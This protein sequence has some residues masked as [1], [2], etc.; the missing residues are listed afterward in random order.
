[1]V[2]SRWPHLDNIMPVPKT[3]FWDHGSLMNGE[4]AQPDQGQMSPVHTVAH[5]GIC[6]ICRRHASVDELAP[7]F[8]SRGIPFTVM[9]DDRWQ[10]IGAV[11]SGVSLETIYASQG[12]QWQDVWVLDVGDHLMPGCL[13]AGEN[14]VL[15]TNE[16][17]R[18]FFVAA[19]RAAERLRFLYC[20]ESG[21]ASATR[22]LEPVM[23]Q[24]EHRR[25]PTH[26]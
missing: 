10:G 14:G 18:L 19:T 16:E 25:V 5:H 11:Q 24:L 20:R 26:T 22:F 12:M 2:A 4:T 23:G 8:R 13:G 7:V 1:M 21:L 9:G 3:F 17:Q 15:T 6:L